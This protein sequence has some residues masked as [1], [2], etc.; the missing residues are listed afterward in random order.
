MSRY[1]RAYYR[2][3]TDGSAAGNKYRHRRSTADRVA[4]ICFSVSVCIC[5]AFAIAASAATLLGLA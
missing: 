4:W 1:E 2:G 3:Y 5:T